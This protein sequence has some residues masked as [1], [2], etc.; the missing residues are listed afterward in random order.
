MSEFFQ[1]LIGIAAFGSMAQLAFM[2][3][4]SIGSVLAGLCALIIEVYC[5]VK[6]INAAIKGK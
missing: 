2:Q 1:Y 4:D 5:V 6:A 3:A